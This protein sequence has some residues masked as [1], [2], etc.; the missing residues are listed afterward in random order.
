MY[1]VFAAIFP[2]FI[3][4]M[5]GNV[6]R[7]SAFLDEHFWVQAEKVTYYILFPALL[8][9]HLAKAE[10]DFASAG[11]L[12]LLAGVV[13]LL[14]SLL[15]FLFAP[16]LRLNGADF[17]S[18]FQGSI[19][20]NTYIGLAVMAVALPAPALTLAAIIVAVMIPLVN[21]LCIAVFARYTHG[22][23]RPVAI[24]LS[25]VRNPLIMASVIGIILNVLPFSL[26]DMLW[27]VVGKLGQMALPLGL[28]AVG[29]GLRL[30]ALRESGKT[31]LWAALIK[32]VLLPALVFVLCS[33]LQIPPLDRAVLVMF[34][35][36]PTASS[37]YILA[38]Q[39]GGNAAMMA[40]LITGETLLSMMSLPLVLLAVS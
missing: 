8:V 15:C 39:L 29:A 11:W 9:E 24:L 6:A 20:F 14:A 33:L 18:F 10:V 35:A 30:Q 7:R 2:V 37:A 40:V 1:P 27:S 5:L 13:P 32:L 3:L 31:L 12:L 21:L 16:W 36:L 23:V 19:R 22:Q 26:P 4:L 28:L 25:I 34:A 38:R 17:T